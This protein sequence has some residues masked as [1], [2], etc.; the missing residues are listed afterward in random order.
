MAET[1]RYLL[2]LSCSKRKR[3]WPATPIPALERYD[4]P[5]FKTIRKTFLEQGKPSNLDI[6]ILSA[7]HGLIACDENITCYDQRMTTLR[8]EE[9]SPLVKAKLDELL[10]KNQY[11]VILINL[12]ELYLFA[13]RDSMNVIKQHRTYYT[14]GRIGERRQQL[15]KWILTLGNQ[16][17]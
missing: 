4:G 13:L 6:M 2:I 7:K 9:L 15:K 17:G 8:A 16:K 10:Q 14:K 12:S 11:E 5:F 1:G 3:T